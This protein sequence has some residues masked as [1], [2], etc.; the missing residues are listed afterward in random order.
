MTLIEPPDDSAE[1][2]PALRHEAQVEWHVVQSAGARARRR[3]R[4]LLPLMTL[5]TVVVVVAA[6]GLTRAVTSAVPG[7]RSA[8]GS[9]LTTAVSS[10][11]PTARASSAP[12]TTAQPAKT[13]AKPAAS[14][15]S[16]PDFRGVAAA[17]A[18]SV[19][20]VL[21]STCQGTGIGSAF[22]ISDT[23]LVTSLRVVSGAV[24]AAVVDDT[25]APRPATVLASDPAHDVAL[26][27]V[28]EGGGDAIPIASAEPRPGS[29]VAAVG[30]P[31]GRSDLTTTSG[32]LLAG[33]AGPR[34]P[35][36][37]DAGLAGAPIIDPAGAVVGSLSAVAGRDQGLIVPVP[38]LRQAIAAAESSAT[39][40][41][42]SC[43]TPTG[44]RSQAQIAGNAPAALVRALQAYF[45]GIN[46][47]HY[48]RAYNTLSARYHGAGS[49]LA[50]ISPGWVS[51]YDFNINV[52]STRSGGNFPTWI[53]FDSIFAAGKGPKP[54]LTCAHW[55]IDYRFVRVGNQLKVNGNKAHGGTSRSYTQC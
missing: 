24:A 8:T 35:S 22:W 2:S 25:G 33:A 39:F 18:P 42:G 19:V 6:I 40:A 55:S 54:E 52:R 13:S 47:A 44:P 5:V 15:V 16:P 3:W 36:K 1:P 21:A 32:Q 46:S 41:P 48:R 43:S 26:L 50:T 11:S 45:G 37:V 23:T 12:A 7:P 31:S 14:T 4:R 34:L 51:T 29:W 28:S 20:R 53:T 10:A 30:Y 9:P 27:E 38:T 49:S 17:V